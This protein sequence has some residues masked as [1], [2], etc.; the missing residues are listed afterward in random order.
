MAIW[1]IEICSQHTANVFALVVMLANIALTLFATR[2]HR[3]ATETMRDAVL[4]ATRRHRLATETMRDA[5]GTAHLYFEVGRAAVAHDVLARLN[6]R[7]RPTDLNELRALC[8]LVL[9]EAHNEVDALTTEPTKG[10]D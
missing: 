10:A 4:F 7:D 8:N 6:D 1:P 9:T 5:M 3:L 2:R